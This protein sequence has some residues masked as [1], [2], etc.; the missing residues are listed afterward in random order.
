MMV[1]PVLLLNCQ[2]SF[3]GAFNTGRVC[4][5]SKSSHQQYR[6]R[7]MSNW[8]AYSYSRSKNNREL[9]SLQ[10]SGKGKQ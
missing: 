5:V 9:Q 7:S 1:L 8:K 6:M 4:S 3:S 2:Q 10:G